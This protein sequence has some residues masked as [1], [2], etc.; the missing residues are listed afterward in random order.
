MSE[1]WED[2][3]FLVI[4]ADEKVLEEVEGKLRFVII[5]VF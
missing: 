5:A 2:E 1:E 3:G 4:W